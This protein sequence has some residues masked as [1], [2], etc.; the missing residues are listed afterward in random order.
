MIKSKFNRASIEET[1][2]KALIKLSKTASDVA[3]IGYAFIVGKQPRF[4]FNRL[5]RTMRIAWDT[6]RSGKHRFFLQSVLPSTN[7]NKQRRSRLAPCTAAS[8][9]SSW[10]MWR[11]SCAISGSSMFALLMLTNRILSCTL[12][13]MQRETRKRSEDVVRKLQKLK[14]TNQMHVHYIL[15]K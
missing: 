9:P 2:G 12:R 10:R 8:P 15:L 4:Q 11:R 3:E 14:V 7:S 5:H 13:D 6:F 1:Y